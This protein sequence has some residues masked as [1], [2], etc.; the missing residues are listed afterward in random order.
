MDTAGYILHITD[1]CK[2]APSPLAE[3][4]GKKWVEERMGITCIW[5]GSAYFDGAFYAVRLWEWIR[6]ERKEGCKIR[7]EVKR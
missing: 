1:Q 2:V 3:C 6:G 5:L 7:G 4:L